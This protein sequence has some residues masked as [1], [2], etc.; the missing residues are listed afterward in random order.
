[1]TKQPFFSVVIP[2]YNRADCIGGT[3]RSIID[4]T[5]GDYEVIVV[6][7]GSEDSPQEAVERVRDSR[8]RLVS[9]PNSGGSAAR[10]KGIDLAVGKYIAFLDSDDRFLP[11]HLEAMHRALSDDT[12]LNLS[13]YSPVIVDRGAGKTFVKPPRSIGPEED[14]SDYVMR[15]RGFVQTSG[16]VVPS[17]V[18]KKVRYR[19]G[20]PFGQDTDF[21]VRLFRAGCKFQMLETPTV[22]W[23]DVEDPKRVSASRKGNRVIGWLEEMKPLISRKAYLGYRGWHV[24]KGLAPRQPVLALTYYFTAL[25]NGC[26]GPKLA[27][28]VMLQIVLPVHSYRRFS[29]FVIGFT[30]REA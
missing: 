18:A 25:I 10:N 4:Q 27:M 7:D 24:A 30:R 16:L 28:V 14:M 12:T 1:M 22:I 23:N 15:D 29:D 3:L 20:L 5:F 13:V 21:A 8:I 11:T 26:Y 9:Q 2:L 17:A 6:D 19:T